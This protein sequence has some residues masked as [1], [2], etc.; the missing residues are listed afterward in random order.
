MPPLSAL[1]RLMRPHQWV[2]NGFVFVGLLFGHAWRDPALLSAALLAF[3]AFCLLSSGV[4]VLNDCVDREQD[5]H[6]PQ[7]RHRPVA[8]GAVSVAMALAL[9]LACLAGGMAVALASSLAPWLFVIYLLLQVVYNMGAKHIVVLDVFII[10]AGF[11][12]RILAG[13]VGI[14]ILPTHWLLLCGLM[15]TLFLGFGKRRAEL[16]ALVDDSAIHRRVLEH[17]SKAMLDQFI[18][19]AASG[20]IVSYALYTVSPETM[21]LHGTRWLIAT[22]PFVLYGLL[23]YLYL[24]H[25]Q[26]GGGDPAREVLT[27]PHLLAS[28]AGWAALVIALLPS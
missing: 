11:M 21:A 15:L 9:G 18:V 25:R 8:S 10:A 23:R 27:D 26:G 2:K 14:G 17:Y 7:K 28:L 6:H 1:V 16:D 12:L 24:L 4:Y 3:A 13:T 22:V 20:A 19:I 5:R